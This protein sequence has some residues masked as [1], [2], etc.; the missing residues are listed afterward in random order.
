MQKAGSPVGLLIFSF[1]FF[2]FFDEFMSLCMFGN[3]WLNFDIVYENVDNLKLWVMFSS[4][5]KDIFLLLTGG[6]GISP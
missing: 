3:F 6:S 2:S 5:R 1:P 4:S